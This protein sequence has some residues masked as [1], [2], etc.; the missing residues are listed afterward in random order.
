LLYENTIWFFFLIFER[1]GRMHETKMYIFFLCFDKN[2][3][4]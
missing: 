3:V 4:F 1:L 2:Q